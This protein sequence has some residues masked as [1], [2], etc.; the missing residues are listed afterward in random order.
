MNAHLPCWRALA[1]LLLT[2]PACLAQMPPPVD[3]DIALESG[4]RVADRG[5]PQ[6]RPLWVRIHHVNAQ[7]LICGSGGPGFDPPFFAPHT[8]F[9]VFAA[10]G[11]LVASSTAPVQQE[12]IIAFGSLWREGQAGSPIMLAPNAFYYIASAAGDTTFTD[13]F[14]F[15]MDNSESGIVRLI[16]VPAPGTSTVLAGLAAVAL[17]RQRR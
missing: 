12:N 13:G 14:H 6:S 4:S 3:L 17:C 11:M 16:V 1:G 10:D 5:F 15:T 8:S 7:F 9:A 2:A